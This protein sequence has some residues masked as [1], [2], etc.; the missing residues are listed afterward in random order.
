MDASNWFWATI[1]I[2]ML[3]VAVVAILEDYFKY[4]SGK[5]RKNN[6]KPNIDIE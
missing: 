4:K 3:C 5:D 6:D 1:I 2:M